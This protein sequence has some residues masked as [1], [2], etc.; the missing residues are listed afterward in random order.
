M[1]P[2]TSLVPYLLFSAYIICCYS[3]TRES[4]VPRSLYVTRYLSVYSSWYLSSCVCVCARFISLNYLLR[5]SILFSRCERE[6]KRRLPNKLFLFLVGIR[7]LDSL[8]PRLSQNVSGQYDWKIIFLITNEEIFSRYFAKRGYNDRGL[9]LRQDN[10]IF[11]YTY[12]G[13]KSAT[14]VGGK[15][16]KVSF[17]VGL[18]VTDG[19]RRRIVC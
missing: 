1:F 5:L 6:S 10:K 19:E 14:P 7:P 2:S 15:E 13:F 17:S 11:I 16:Q 18:V 8:G 4:P 12:L 3:C 9:Q